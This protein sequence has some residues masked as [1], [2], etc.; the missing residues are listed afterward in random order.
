[1]ATF[2][3][4]AREQSA[5]EETLKVGFKLVPEIRFGKP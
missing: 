5:P 3:L 2:Q 1:M 4:T